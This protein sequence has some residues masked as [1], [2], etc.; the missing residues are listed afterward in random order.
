M[1][2]LSSEVGRV[3]MASVE[4][5]RHIRL[6]GE[7]DVYTAP[8]V[9]EQV[10]T[11]MRRGETRIVFDLEHTTFLDS[12]ILRIFLT[13]RRHTLSSGGEVVLL[14]RPG[15]V[16]RLLG[17]LE[18]DRLVRICTPEEWRCRTAAVH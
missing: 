12:S 1:H 8:A 15:F 6:I 4:G 9:H 17:L 7:C 18:M 16:R 13:A 5:A 3:E 10:C 14:C 2:Q 11:L